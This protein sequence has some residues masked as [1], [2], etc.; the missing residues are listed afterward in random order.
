V[1][2]T[3]HVVGFVRRHQASRAV[4]GVEFLDGPLSGSLETLALWIAIDDTLVDELNRLGY[5]PAGSLHAAEHAMIA[6]LPLFVL[7]DRRDVGGVSIV[8]AH[9]Q[10]DRATIFIYDG[11]PGGIGYAEEAYRSFGDLAGATRDLIEACG[12]ERGCYAC[13]QSPKCGNQNR[14]LDK[15]GA[16]HLLGRL[17][18]GERG[19]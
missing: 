3:R 14:P 10:T 17:L 12:C 13:I 11:Y 15:A 5:D 2:V 19:R 7:G 6:L 8:P 9:A 18:E 16:V 4:T 1:R